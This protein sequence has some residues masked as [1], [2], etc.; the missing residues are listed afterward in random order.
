MR[1]FLRV[2]LLAVTPIVAAG[3]QQK[4]RELSTDRPDRTESPYT[5]DARHI[6]VEM[7]ALN[8]VDGVRDGSGSRSIGFGAVNAKI[9]LSR[10][11][12]IQ[13][14]TQLLSV[15]RQEIAGVFGPKSVSGASDLTT[16]LKINLWGDDE[17]RTAF[18]VMPYV[19][20]LLSRPADERTLS[21][22]LILPLAL[23]LGAGWGM[24]LMSELDIVPRESGSGHRLNAMHSVTVSHDIAGPFG[25][26]GELAAETITTDRMRLV[27]TG[28]VGL[29]IAPTANLQFDLGANLGLNRYADRLTAFV[30]VSRRY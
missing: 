15:D 4:L 24:G 19:T 27:P 23:D 10:N 3:A 6:Q 11:I 28:D 16:R 13:F 1:S 25:G 29:T 5:V 7:D 14:V 12:D 8:L 21:G 22:G 30:G 26:Y 20:C 17:G 2:A 18:A 9:G